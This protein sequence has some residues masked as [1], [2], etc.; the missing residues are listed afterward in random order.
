VL[1]NRILVL[2][3]LGRL[4]EALATCDRVLALDPRCADDPVDAGYASA[5]EPLI[6]H[7]QPVAW[8]HGHVH[9]S[10][11]YVVASTRVICNPRGYADEPNREFDPG[12]VITV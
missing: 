3:E 4:R 7:L 9:R 12:L 10:V 5:L 2:V 11:D 8:I 6:E 1:N